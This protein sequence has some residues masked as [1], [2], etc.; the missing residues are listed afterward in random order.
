M[1]NFVCLQFSIFLL[2]PR[3]KVQ[4][5]TLIPLAQTSLVLFNAMVGAGYSTTMVISTVY[6][7]ANYAFQSSIIQ[8]YVRTILST[9]F[10]FSQYVTAGLKSQ[11]LPIAFLEAYNVMILICALCFK[12]F[13]SIQGQQIV[14]IYSFGSGQYQII[15]VILFLLLGKM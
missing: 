2:L 9:R 5:R 13:Q 15:H 11:V 6:F 12:L 8:M 3:I 4:C 10:H 14:V 7:L 1:T